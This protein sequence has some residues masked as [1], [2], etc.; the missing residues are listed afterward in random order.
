[1]TTK[2]AMQVIEGEVKW[3][4]AHVP[5]GQ[6]ERDKGFIKGLR[7]LHGLFDSISMLERS[8]GDD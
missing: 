5:E 7:H 2:E 4:E 6:T 8:E 3:H 1:M